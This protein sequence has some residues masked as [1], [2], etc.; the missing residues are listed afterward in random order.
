[1]RSRPSSR[2]ASA[3]ATGV[4]SSASRQARC[5]SSSTVVVGCRC[6]A[7]R[8]AVASSSSRSARASGDDEGAL[9]SSEEPKVRGAE[10]RRLEGAPAPTTLDGA[11]A[12]ASPSARRT[13]S[14]TSGGSSPATYTR[15][16]SLPGWRTTTQAL[17]SAWVTSTVTLVIFV[18]AID[19]L[20]G[21]TPGARVT[22]PRRGDEAA[23]ARRGQGQVLSAAPQGE[24]HGGGSAGKI[25]GPELVEEAL[26]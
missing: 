18:S 14:A 22:S 9:I 20:Q 15:C 7:R 5:S 13:S 26:G 17:V 23:S 25:V 2:E 4:L 16:A 10:E 6:P 11:A 19:P 1:S 8:T 21:V 12:S 24:A 3:R